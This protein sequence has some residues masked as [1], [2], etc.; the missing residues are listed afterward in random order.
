MEQMVMNYTYLNTGLAFHFN[1]QRFISQKD[2]TIYCRAKKP[3]RIYV[4]PS[5]YLVSDDIEIALSHSVQYGDEYYSFV[6]GQYTV[7]GGTHFTSFP[8]RHGGSGARV[9][10]KRLRYGGYSRS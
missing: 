6:N 4:T 1:G 8:R 5:L 2:Y 10:Q 3:W 7:Q 9:L